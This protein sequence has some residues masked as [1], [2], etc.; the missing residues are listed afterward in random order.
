M[1][2]ASQGLTP[3]ASVLAG[4]VLQF[5]G[6][7]WLLFICAIGFSITAVFGLFNKKIKEI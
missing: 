4:A 1:S 6:S 3:I 7:T 5:M 2:V